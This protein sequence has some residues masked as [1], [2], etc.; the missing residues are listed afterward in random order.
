MCSECG[1]YARWVEDE[2]ERIEEEEMEEYDKERAE[3]DG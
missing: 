1:C 2:I 3:E